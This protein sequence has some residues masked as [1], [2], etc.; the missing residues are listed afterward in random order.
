MGKYSKYQ[1]QKHIQ[2]DLNSL[3]DSSNKNNI[4]N[5]TKVH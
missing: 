5:G 4:N 1:Y 2:I 3:K